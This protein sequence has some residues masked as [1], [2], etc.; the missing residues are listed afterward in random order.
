MP[1]ENV[2]VFELRT[3]SLQTFGSVPQEYGCYTDC[4][5]LLSVSYAP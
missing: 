5:M 2:E 3:H 4:L 1:V